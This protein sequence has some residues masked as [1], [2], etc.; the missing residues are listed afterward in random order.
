M[1][2]TS[3]ALLAGAS[4]LASA[5]PADKNAGKAVHRR[6]M[7]ITSY[8]MPTSSNY[9][10]SQAAKSDSS[11]S[12]LKRSTYV[13]TATAVVNKIAPNAEFRVKSDH[14][15]GKN[16]VAHV[17]FKQTMNGLDIGNAD[18]NVNINADGSVMSYGHS[19]YTGKV[20]SSP[21]QKREFSSPMAAL[22]GA[23]T[24]LKL[25]LSMTKDVSVEDLEDIEAYTIKG[26]SGAV[27]DPTARL[28]YV[29]KQNGDLA[30]SWKVETNLRTSWLHS[31]V[32]AA[33]SS[34]IH[35]VI[36]WVWAA[37][38]K[39]YPWE[40]DSPENGERT[41]VAD[42]WEVAA[43][44]FTWESDG[45]TNYTT[46][47][48][49][50]G[51]AEQDWYG[52]GESI[53][54]YAPESDDLKFEYDVDHSARD[55]NTYRDASITQQ[56]YTANF[57]HDVLYDLGFDEAAGNFQMENG[58]KG[59][60]DG[61]YV[62][63]SAQDSYTT[64]NAF[65]TPPVDG[66][67]GIMQMFLWTTANPVRDCTFEKDVVVHEYTHGLSTRLTG[68]PDN[69][70]CLSSGEAAGMGEGWSDFFA[71]ANSVKA[72]MTGNDHAV[73]GAWVAND[74]E[75]IRTVP[76]TTDMTA[77]PNTYETLNGLSEEHDIGETWATTL[78]EVL[79]A[80]VEKYGKNDGPKPVFGDDGVPV[81]GVFLAQ[82]LTMDGMALQPCNPT[83]VS[84]RDGIIDADM[85]L[86]GGANLCELWTAFAKR[87]LGVDA[88][89]IDDTHRTVSFDLPDGVC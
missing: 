38:Y 44:P 47:R 87:G 76:Y 17:Y 25:P 28:M 30:L 61:D 27:K 13:E 36:D 51:L 4:M 64:N 11:L 8:K 75:G 78:W 15:V 74:P 77:N 5:H 84:A 60:K 70:D 52:S 23:M 83:F 7:D 45:T 80:L 42:P 41:V 69:S 81:D 24:T 57:Y 63:L 50:N 53:D 71:L 21:L 43:S 2:S 26:I 49:N 55:P 86:T 14:Y 58:D 82:K 48:G 34:K 72:N 16:G 40:V 39:V 62:I 67:N 89:F 66:E 85:A 6:D 33:D 22:K 31:Y 73:I 68:G 12:L 9:V 65:F 88:E 20:P 56:F 46:T 19:F 37:T 18:F 1:K 79:W 35:G 59:G 3:L 32:D 10:N 54:G 29:V